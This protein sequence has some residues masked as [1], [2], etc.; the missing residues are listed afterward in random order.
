M[1]REHQVVEQPL[2]DRAARVRQVRILDVEVAH[3]VAVG[4]PTRSRFLLGHGSFDGPR[5]LGRI[6]AGRDLRVVGLRSVAHS[7]GTRVSVSVSLGGVR[8]S[9]TTIT[10]TRY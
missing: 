4:S 5:G 3:V 8:I 6:V 10:K 2:G 1:G 7:V 9:K